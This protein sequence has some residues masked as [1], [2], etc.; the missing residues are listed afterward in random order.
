MVFSG[1]RDMYMHVDSSLGALL[2][3][4]NLPN[5]M[6]WCKRCQY[7]CLEDDEFE[8]Y[9][10]MLADEQRYAT[11]AVLAMGFYTAYHVVK[12]SAKGIRFL[13]KVLKR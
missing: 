1:I 2:G 10:T 4:K 5:Q 7:D 11:W 12:G 8:A 13:Y 9:E 6:T 3:D